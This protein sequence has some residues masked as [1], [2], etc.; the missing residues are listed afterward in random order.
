MTKFGKSEKPDHSVSYSKLYGFCS[1]RTGT[2]KDI[3]KEIWRFQYILGMERELEATKSQDGRNP[4]PKLK[5]QKSDYP[6]WDTGLSDFF[7]KR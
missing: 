7:Q 6:V 5:S 4:V 2:W 3:N 1:F